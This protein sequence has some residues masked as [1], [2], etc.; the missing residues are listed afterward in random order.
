MDRNL[1]LLS[2]QIFCSLSHTHTL[3]LSLFHCTSLSPTYTLALSLSL[4]LS[5]SGYAMDLCKKYLLH[6]GQTSACNQ[7]ISTTMHTT[8]STIY[9]STI[10]YTCMW[11]AQSLKIQCATLQI[12]PRKQ[13]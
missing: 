3:P 7:L 2:L 12:S 10:Y 8:S 1:L 5:L 9:H 6:I 4:S 11:N 13:F